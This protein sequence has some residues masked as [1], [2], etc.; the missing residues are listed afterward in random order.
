V[1]ET[2]FYD[3]EKDIQT[4]RQTHRETDR[5]V[6]RLYCRLLTWRQVRIYDTVG[7]AE[8]FNYYRLP[9]YWAGTELVIGT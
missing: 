2:L 4:H 6:D 5:D 8:S 3:P 7:V 1:T 9:L